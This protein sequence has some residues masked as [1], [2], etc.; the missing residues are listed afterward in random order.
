MM[1]FIGTNHFTTVPTYGTTTR[2]D[3]LT[4]DEF[5]RL[6]EHIYG[7]P[8]EAPPWGGFL[9]ALRQRLG[10]SH[11]TLILRPAMPER[12]SLLVVA[13]PTRV[14]S[15]DLYNSRFFE[16][17]PFVGLPHDE[18][19][20]AAELIGEQRWL[21]SVCYREYLQPLDIRHVLGIDLAPSQ[22]G[23]DCRLRATRSSTQLPFDDN[24]KALFQIVLPHLK[25]SMRLCSHMEQVNVERR[26][27]A[28]AVERMQVGTVILDEKGRLLSVNGEAKAILDAKDG[29]ALVGGSLK[30]DHG[31]ENV[32]L[33]S[34]INAILSGRARS[35]P[36]VVD[37]VSITRPSGRTK[38][39]VL[40]REVPADEWSEAWNRP[41]VAIFLRDPEHPAPRSIDALRRLFELTHAEAS[42]AMLLAG[43]MALDEASEQLN[44]RRNTARAHLRSIFSKMGVRRQTELVRQVL[45]SVVQLG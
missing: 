23:E 42:L 10:A 22:E 43:G 33:Q 31:N 21:E 15:L 6:V 20:V 9:E 37:A 5:S 28:G 45:N 40:V 36:S 8:L 41:K 24:D 39:T 30:A 13:G 19:V 4:H 27:L 18:V 35:V 3:L 25:Q 38:L 17:D 26:L 29:L 14:E 7:G 2:P 44:I 16:L 12:P 11:V 1:Q 32:Q 34:L